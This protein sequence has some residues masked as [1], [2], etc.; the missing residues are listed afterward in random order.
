MVDS[1]ASSRL[2]L[3]SANCKELS[4]AIDVGAIV[5]TL[6]PGET[7]IETIETWFEL[8]KR[9]IS[10]AGCLESPAI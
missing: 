4:D 7:R 9:R 5:G 3:T 2:G 1:R 6:D 10:G 8:W